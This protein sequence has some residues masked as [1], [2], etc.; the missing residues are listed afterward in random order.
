MSSLAPSDLTGAFTTESAPDESYRAIFDA[1]NDAI[2]VHDLETGAVVDANRRA[3]DFTG[4]TLAALRANG[5]AYI[6]AVE[7]FTLERAQEHLRRAA[8]G[9]PQ[10]FEWRMREA[11]TGALRWVEVTLERVAIG[12]ADRL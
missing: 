9:T 6:A 3:C 1:S 4:A 8:E 5:L 2:F 7:P 12:R 11:A 10:R